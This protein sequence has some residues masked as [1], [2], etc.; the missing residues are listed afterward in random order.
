MSG[1]RHTPLPWKA[2]GPEVFALDADGNFN[3][4]VATAW[5]FPYLGPGS[6]EAVANAEL[7][8]R[9]VNAHADLLAACESAAEAFEALELLDEAGLARAAATVCHVAIDKARGI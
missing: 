3:C 5:S 6:D 8:V 4:H 1:P 7:I 2:D 9:A